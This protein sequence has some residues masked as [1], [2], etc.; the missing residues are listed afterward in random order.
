[1]K[2]N[3]KMELFYI[4]RT[5]HSNIANDFP[6][7]LAQILNQPPDA[8]NRQPDMNEASL[9]RSYMIGAAI[10]F[11]FALRF[12]AIVDSIFFLISMLFRTRL[13]ISVIVTPGRTAFTLIP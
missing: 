6:E 12:I 13:V 8:S 9:E 2:D 11:T 3:K 5:I 10:S 7:V 1:M 4:R